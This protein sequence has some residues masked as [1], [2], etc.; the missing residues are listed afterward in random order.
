MRL[1]VAET[2]LLEPV[3]A[4]A[5]VL[6]E[7]SAGALGRRS[8]GEAAATVFFTGR[9]VAATAAFVAAATAEVSLDL[10]GTA[11]VFRKGLGRRAG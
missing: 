10:S 11:C 8:R 1:T 5:A 9:G 2:L 6:F 7:A 4:A 3:A